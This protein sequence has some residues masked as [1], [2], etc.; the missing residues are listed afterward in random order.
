MCRL[1]CSRTR[2]RVAMV[3][4]VTRQS[5]VVVREKSPTARRLPESVLVDT[6]HEQLG[7]A[8]HPVPEPGVERTEKRARASYI[9]GYSRARR[10]APARRVASGIHPGENP[11]LARRVLLKS[12]EMTDR[13]LGLARTL[14]TLSEVQSFQW[15]THTRS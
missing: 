12:V 1:S 9:T 15:A 3:G 4:V 7:V 6:Q 13:L 11:D 2:R 8:T 14:G 10:G 5:L